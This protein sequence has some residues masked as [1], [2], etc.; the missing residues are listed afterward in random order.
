MLE[1]PWFESAV[2]RARLGGA[3]GPVL[4][5]DPVGLDSDSQ[6]ILPRPE[7]SASILAR[8]AAMSRDLDPSIV[9]DE[10]GCVRRSPDNHVV[11]EEV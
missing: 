10:N 6:P 4:R 2:F 5:L 8:F 3:D 7:V 9:V 11:V 1:G